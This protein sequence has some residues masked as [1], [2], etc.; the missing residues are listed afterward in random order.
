MSNISQLVNSQDSLGSVATHIG[1]CLWWTLPKTSVDRQ[2]LENTAE[3]CGVPD[4]YLPEPIKFIGAVR[5]ALSEVKTPLDK[6]KVLLREIKDDKNELL[7]SITFERVSVSKKTAEHQQLGLVSADKLNETLTVILDPTYSTYGSENQLVKL[8]DN[9]LQNAYTD[10]KLHN[11]ND[12]R[13]VITRFTSECAISLRSSGGIYFV[14]LTHQSML[15]AIAKF[16]TEV[17]PG[18]TMYIKPEYVMQD[19]DLSAL[20]AVTQSEL[21]S[22]LV[23]LEDQFTSLQ[24]EIDSIVSAGNQPTRKKQNKL[25]DQLSEYNS[26]RD[27]ISTFSSTLNFTSD[28]LTSKLNRLHHDMEIKLNKLKIKIKSDLRANNFVDADTEVTTPIHTVST[29]KSKDQISAA[30]LPRP[31]ISKSALQAISS[32]DAMLADLD[33]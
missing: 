3:Y 30:K 25:L 26:M 28:N 31:K 5:R 19:S 27:R 2:I 22:E 23:K 24:S 4:R 18:A 16:V 13:S 29:Q 32:I 7:L 11:T 1:S 9:Y 6:E 21:A 33:I 17:S 14:P 12:I 20:R 15:D 10:C 8:V